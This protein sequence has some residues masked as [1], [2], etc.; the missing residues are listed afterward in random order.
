M[1]EQTDMIN[2]PRHYEANRYSCEPADLT[3]MLPHPIASAVEYILR[4]PFKGTEVA[5][6]K[7]AQWWLAR[8]YDT[9][10]FWNEDG[11]LRYEFTACWDETAFNAAMF[12]MSTKSQM[13]C[14][15]YFGG[16]IYRSNV[17]EV[18]DMLKDRIEQLEATEKKNDA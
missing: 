6:L 15:L 5:D 8:A 4:A 14:A 10:A 9:E 1:T 13:V 12:A 11:D 18:I 7:K 2:H 3:T 17:A 16:D